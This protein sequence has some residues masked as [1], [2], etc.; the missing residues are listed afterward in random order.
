MS[1]PKKS[2]VWSVVLLLFYMTA[3]THLLIRLWCMMKSGFPKTAGDDQLSG[4]TEKELQS[5]SQSQTCSK[6][7]HGHWWSAA[8]LITR[9]FWILAKPL[10]L[11]HMLNKS[12]RCTGNCNACSQYWSTERDQFFSTTVPNCMSHNQH[13]KRWTHCTTK[14]CLIRHIHLTS[15]QLKTISWSIS[16]SFCREMLPQPARKCFC[17][18]N[19]QENASATTTRTRF[20]LVWEDHLRGWNQAMFRRWLLTVYRSWTSVAT[21][22]APG[23]PSSLQTGPTIQTDSGHPCYCLS[24]I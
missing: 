22:L 12:M 6:K 1:W 18:H 8:C 7:S 14:F 9:A 13:F 16:T 2:L 19:Q 15:C 20:P 24:W 3:T 21:F 10:H 11:R 23:H 5:T 4:W 17:N